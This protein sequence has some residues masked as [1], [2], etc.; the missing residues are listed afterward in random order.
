MAK[1]HVGTVRSI[2]E[3]LVHIYDEYVRD[4]VSIHSLIWLLVSIFKFVLFMIMVTGA[5]P[6]YF[7]ICRMIWP[8]SASEWIK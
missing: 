4:W 8:L 7:L 3:N 5:R 6:L 2:Y 1:S